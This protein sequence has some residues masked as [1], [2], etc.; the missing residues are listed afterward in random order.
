MLDT[1]HIHQS[2][3]TF[4]TQH[5]NEGLDTI[6]TTTGP[7]AKISPN[8][9]SNIP[10]SSPISTNA[11]P[12]KLF[13]PSPHN[14]QQNTVTKYL[15]NRAMS[16]HSMNSSNS[17]LNAGSAISRH[18][19]VSVNRREFSAPTPGQLD[20][21]AEKVHQNESQSR[22]PRAK[23]EVK[24]PVGSALSAIRLQ[25]SNPSN[26][27]LVP[28][29]ETK[30]ESSEIIQDY[31]DFALNEEETARQQRQKS[32]HSKIYHDKVTTY[33]T[34][35]TEQRKQEE[36]NKKKKEDRIKKRQLLLS[37]RVLAEANERKL[38]EAEDALVQDNEDNT[39]LE[40]SAV[41][42][43]AT[44]GKINNLT[45][46]SIGKQLSVD[47]APKKSIKSKAEKNGDST[48]SNAK[49]SPIRQI[50]S[51]SNNTSSKNEFVDDSVNEKERS[52]SVSRTKQSV[53][54]A[55]KLDSSTSKGTFVA[56][57]HLMFF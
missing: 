43:S 19:E 18:P 8:D 56:F 28:T 10:K 31:N 13:D 15:K 7:A 33:L 21:V 47:D 2:D 44:S 38:M 45:T 22:I 3:N 25:H 37:V 27:L 35:L 49:G 46:K 5:D 55:N 1:S 42:T 12:E 57:F 11:L 29:L 54:V 26:E 51:S 23:K 24:P 53:S 6:D 34:S 4:T 9:K 16:D 39:G 40:T 36:L 32:I 52:S 48:P 20:S 50:K 17:N 41:K 14:Q 30:K